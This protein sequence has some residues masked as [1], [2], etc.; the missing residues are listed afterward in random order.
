MKHLT[1]S[2][3]ARSVWRRRIWF[4]VPVLLGLVGAVAAYKVLPRKYKAF[5]A[6]LVEPQRVPADYVK[7]TVTTDIEERLRTIEP[8][9]KNRDNLERIIR[10]VGLY[11]ELQRRGYL[12]D[13]VGQ[14]RND[15]TVQLQGDTF[16]IFFRGEDPVKVARTAN[17]VAEL[18][19][20]SNLALRENQAQ[21]TSAFLEHELERTKHRLEFQE[22]RIAAFK[23]LNMGDL[24]E[25]R[26]TNLRSVE[27]L[28]TKLEI[29]M[30]AL[31]KAETRKLLLQTQI[32]EMKRYPTTSRSRRAAGRVGVPEAPAGPT[33][34][35]QLRSQLAE[36]RARYT[37]RHPDVI[38]A[39][40]E[41]EQLERM[42][43]EKPPA[44]VAVAAAPSDDSGDDEEP[45]APRVDPTFKAELASVEM[46]IRSLKSERG[47]ILADISSVQARLESVPR[48][49]QELLSLTRDY[50]NIKRSYESLLDKRLNA[51]LY[52][53][54]EKSQ[55]G[56]RFT[57]IERALPPAVPYS[58]NRL[59][60]LA[61]G[62]VLGSLLGL[63]A[64]L[65]RE[66]TDPTYSNAE[67]LQEAFPGVPLLATI[68][69]FQGARD[70]SR[71]RRR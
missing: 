40:A 47:R 44:P 64:V 10:E 18:F 60:T 4:L 22:A 34:L 5:T 27:Q 61:A 3:L 59:L 35:E 67:S 19:I 55:Q 63:L 26:D 54:L 16:Y 62:L 25:Q 2:D 58:P 49:E 65:L 20:Q 31:D 36:L 24:P 30:D 29:N 45:A 8:Q 23:Q 50:D 38:R 51:R 52:E 43:R 33:R 70:A 15:L 57:M 37:D 1:I 68:P 32:A 6:V 42:E 28:Q 9:I 12:G 17:R 69:V 66:R 39:Q 14:M 21:G 56:E 41:L 46:E 13:A 53:N 11:P 71:T 7:P 48:V